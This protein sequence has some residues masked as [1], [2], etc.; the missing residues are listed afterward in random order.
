LVLA[1]AAVPMPVNEASMSN[2]T[3]RLVNGLLK[4]NN[5]LT[6]ISNEIESLKIDR[7]INASINLKRLGLDIFPSIKRCSKKL[8]I[9]GTMTDSITFAQRAASA[10]KFYISLTGLYEAYTIPARLV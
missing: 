5:N 9:V 7:D 8:V 1:I 4:N 2:N 6:F 10:R 3:C